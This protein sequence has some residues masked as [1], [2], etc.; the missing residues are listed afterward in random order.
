MS[1]FRRRYPEAEFPRTPLESTREG[2]EG[3]DHRL[4]AILEAAEND[5]TIITALLEAIGGVSTVEIEKALRKHLI[6]TDGK[7]DAERCST[8]TASLENVCR[9]AGSFGSDAI[10]DGNQENVLPLSSKAPLLGGTS[11]QTATVALKIVTDVIGSLTPSQATPGPVRTAE[12]LALIERGRRIDKIISTMGR[13][14]AA[15]ALVQIM[16]EDEKSKK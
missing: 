9:N 2:R 5:V 3:K 15:R 13:E 10:H 7:I 12:E 4:L 11:S 8:L 6:S 1:E 16:G 14:A